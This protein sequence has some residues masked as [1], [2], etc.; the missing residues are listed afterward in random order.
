MG[1]IVGEGNV[2][3]SLQI[4]Q[5]LLLVIFIP[6]HISNIC[7]KFTFCLRSPKGL[8]AVPNTSFLCCCKE[9]KYLCLGIFPDIIFRFHNIRM[10]KYLAGSR[11]LTVY[12]YQHIAIC[13]NKAKS[14]PTHS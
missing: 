4:L 9:N 13:F 3:C 2:R 14:N 11:R 8:K 10:T 12:I 5:G 1:E 7:I 6:L